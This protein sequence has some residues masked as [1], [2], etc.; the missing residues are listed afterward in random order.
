MDPTHTDSHAVDSLVKG[1]MYVLVVRL[2]VGFSK[3]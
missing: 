1:T 2:L 3:V